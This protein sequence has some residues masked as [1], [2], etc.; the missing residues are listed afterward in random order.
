MTLGDMD[1]EGHGGWQAPAPT[2]VAAV[3]LRSWG[4]L[5]NVAQDELKESP[6]L[7][8]LIV[9]HM[10]VLCSL[11]FEANLLTCSSTVVERTGC[12]PA[13]MLH[14]GGLSSSPFV[15]L[16]SDT[17]LEND[18]IAVQ[19]VKRAE[20]LPDTDPFETEEPH[21]VLPAPVDLHG[22]GASSV[23]DTRV[24]SLGCT[25]SPHS[26]AESASAEL[27]SGVLHR[28]RGRGGSLAPPGLWAPS[29]RRPLHI[30]GIFAPP[31]VCAPEAASIP[32][33][34]W[35]SP[36]LPLIVSSSQ[37][38]D[39]ACHYLSASLGILSQDK[40]SRWWRLP[41]ESCRSGVDFS[42]FPAVYGSDGNC[43]VSHVAAISEDV[44]DNDYDDSW[45]VRPRRLRQ[46]EETASAAAS[47]GWEEAADFA[48]AKAMHMHL[49]RRAN[50]GV[51]SVVEVAVITARLLPR[52]RLSLGPKRK[53]SPPPSPGLG[54]PKRA[55]FEWP[56]RESSQPWGLS[57]LQQAQ[58]RGHNGVN[59]AIHSCLSVAD[60]LSLFV[61]D[62]RH[63]TRFCMCNHCQSVGGR[64]SYE[65][66]SRRSRREKVPAVPHEDFME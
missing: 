58:W 59:V 60:I 50:G 40:H 4:V 49:E 57:D 29:S 21:R 5:E 11:L 34:R 62:L 15:V 47:A 16:D 37:W 31:G 55:P 17:C 19:M 63:A 12:S 51:E 56:R 23:S 13:G 66:Y 32:F 8:E 22:G 33:P 52:P 46:P 24:T 44:S 38:Q 39:C 35:V 14:S 28:I 64:T 7:V 26:A 20:L 65:A 1:S 6:A 61:L 30:R 41:A 54:V 9:V 2:R 43:A 53:R 27:Y 36:T 25:L 48:L 3:R 10:N 42:R 18:P 45:L